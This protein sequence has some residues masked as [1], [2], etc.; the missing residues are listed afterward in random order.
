[1]EIERAVALIQRAVQVDSAPVTVAAV[2]YR[3]VPGGHADLGALV[4]TVSPAK[5]DIAVSKAPTNVRQHT[6][7]CH[8]PADCFGR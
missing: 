4:P 2:A 3:R 7:P 1:M 5:A 8:L 6:A